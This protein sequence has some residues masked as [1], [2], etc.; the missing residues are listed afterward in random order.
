[1]ST[2]VRNPF[3]LCHVGPI[4]VP[5]FALVELRQGGIGNKVRKHV[6][7]PP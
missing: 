4:K 1:M 7:L 6:A 3:A 5:E 2:N